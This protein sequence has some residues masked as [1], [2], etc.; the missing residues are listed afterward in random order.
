MKVLIIEDDFALSELIAEKVSELG[1]PFESVHSGN[2]AINWLKENTPYIM[3][4]DYGLPDMNG[5]EFIASLQKIGQAIPPFL[6][7]TGQGDELIAVEMM[8]LG[9]KDYLVKSTVFL[10]LLPT[11]INRVVKE[12]ENE[13]KQK[14]IENALIQSENRFRLLYENAPLPYQSLD[15]NGFFLDVNSAWLNALK[16]RKEDV[17]GK[18][19]SDFMTNE[20]KYLLKDNFSKFK[21]EGEIHDA[22]FTMIRGDGEQILVS[23]QGKISFD[24][25]GNFKQTHCIF[26]DITKQKEAENKLLASEEK[27]RKAFMISPDAINITRLSD[28]EYISINQGFTNIMGYTEDDIIGK[29]SI[30]TNIWNN[31]EDRKKLVEELKLNGYCENLEAQFRAK[32]G[33]F[34]Y[35][36]MSASIIELAGKK[37]IISITRDITKR[38]QDE[39]ALRESEGKFRSIV[40]NTEEILFMLD[41]NG[42][43][44][45]SEGKGLNKLGLKPG[46]VVGLSAYDFYKDFPE[47]IK[48]IKTALGGERFIDKIAI[49]DIY[50]DIWYSPNINDNGD[51]LGLIGMAVNITGQVKAENTIKKNERELNYIVNSGNVYIIKTDLNGNYTFVNQ[52][53]MENFGWIFE[54][55][56]IIG[57]NSLITIL[58][59]DHQKVI[60]I[61]V[62]CIE[63]PG[64]PFEVEIRKP[65][66]NNTHLTTLWQFACLNDHMGNPIEML[67][68]G[69]DITDRKKTELEIKK[70]SNAVSQSPTSIVITDLGGKI[71]YT[72]NY[73]TKTSGYT[74]NEVVGKNPRILKSG[75]QQKEF[76][77]E[78]WDTILLGKNWSGV[79]HNKRKN[80]ELFWESAII[81]PVKNDDGKITNFVA[82][83]EDITEKVERD[84]ELKKYR[85]SLED[86]VALRTEEL[87]VLNKELVAQLE[88][89]KE[90]DAQLA[91]S[92][93]KEK[94]INELKTKF[95]ATV[96]HEF[97]TP[98]AALF[99]STQ[100]I[101]R[102]AKS[103]SEE[104]LKAQHE[105][106]ESTTAYLTQLLDEVLTISRA[107]R[108]ILTNNPEPLNINNFVESIFDQLQHTLTQKHNL[109]FNN[110]IDF[111]IIR[112]D[113]K[114]L[115]H[116]LLNLL[117]NAIKYS[118]N[119]GNIELNI[120]TENDN[121]IISVADNGLGIPEDE[122][123]Y[124]FDA[125]YRTKNSAGINGTGLGL[126]ILK[127]S[128]DVIGGTVSVDSKVGEGAKF[129]VRIPNYE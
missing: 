76:Y 44:T 105:R 21:D 83:K 82:I 123:K 48:G 30:H 1:F 113:K 114:L 111:E 93:S 42:I 96:S 24:E 33:S 43:F 51:I 128:L 63:S 122:I 22:Q 56:E 19:F 121:L 79:F 17:I 102:Y 45:L 115:N 31:V 89:E 40:T 88:K 28:G 66:H 16:L 2:E 32:D 60:D 10:D 11:V 72:N 74:F 3:I 26:S 92:L 97:R 64:K 39:E 99:S 61:S 103:W 37:H 98:L 15:L 68:V 59:A 71:E 86:L 126:N 69:I 124:I 25:F 49:G 106:I 95:I 78:L 58:Q 120:S 101:Q 117:T 6:V 70:L 75:E 81:S 65:L 119:G 46:Q 109:V 110:K 112:I 84:L 91:E 13:K 62:K 53:F 4:L 108:E 104:K 36:L 100:I 125:F 127:R 94:E 12:V 29:S 55:K 35:G 23:Y 77:K 67:C 85:E 8:K 5:K 27:F 90:L 118:P 116:I 7:S 52:K 34:R 50:F 80:G 107:D 47:I 38:K 9:A 14:Q 57:A 129:I 20:S 18:H 41:N 54:G 87:N 73:F